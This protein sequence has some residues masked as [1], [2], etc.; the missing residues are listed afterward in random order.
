[1]V[2]AQVDVV[3]EAVHYA[4]S[5]EVEWVRVY[6]RRG[7]TY[8]DRLIKTRG[9]LIH[10]LR[11]GKRVFGGKRIPLMASTFELFTPIDYIR[12]EGNFILKSGKKESLQDRLADIPIL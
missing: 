11:N 9:E 1:M 7:P 3:V 8:S 4:S 6:E 12:Q 2:K 10:L 5:G